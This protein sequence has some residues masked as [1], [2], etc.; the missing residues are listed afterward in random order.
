MR[1]PRAT[2]RR[3]A[4]RAGAG[5]ALAAALLVCLAALPAARSDPSYEIVATGVA[6]PLEL[7]MDGRSIVILSPGWRGDAAGEIYRLDLDRP[8]PADLSRAG[9]SA[10]RNI[11]LRRQTASSPT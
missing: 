2:T 11:R 3:R 7:A 8:L 5:G 10:S 4:G 9:V 6:R 1:R